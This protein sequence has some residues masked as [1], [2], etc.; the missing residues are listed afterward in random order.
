M[1]GE[2]LVKVI[3]PQLPPPPA[4]ILTDEDYMN[5]KRKTIEDAYQRFVKELDFNQDLLPDFFYDVL[6]ADGA[7]PKNCFENKLKAS[8]DK[9]QKQKH[10]DIMFKEATEK[11]RNNGKE[12]DDDKDDG[13]GRYEHTGHIGESIKKLRL[14]AAYGMLNKSPVVVTVSKQTIVKDYFFWLLKNDI[15]NIYAPKKEE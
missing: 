5:D 8:K 12:I 4:K 10:V 13:K 3:T 14:L 7:I 2:T 9:I 11:R 15:E 6:E 1:H